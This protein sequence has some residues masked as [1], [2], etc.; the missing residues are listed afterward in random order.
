MK[1]VT[2]EEMQS[3]EREAN[4]SG[5]TYE[6]MMEHAGNGLA[7]EVEQAYKHLKS[8]GVLGLVGPGN[9]GGDTLVALA[10][11]VEKGW[12]A[13]AYILKVRP[14][15]D[16][17]VNRLIS[18]GGSV[19]PIDQDPEFEKL[20]GAVQSHEVIMDGVLGTGITLPLKGK[21]AKSLTFIQ[22]VLDQM[23]KKPKIVAVDCPSGVDCDTGKTAPESLAADLTVT[24]AA[25]KVGLLKFPANDLIGELRLVGIGLDDQDSRSMNWQSI[26]REVVDADWVRRRLP[27]RP[28]E[29]HKGTFGTALIVAGSVN[30]T[31]AGLLAGKGA[32]LAGVGL[33]TMAV[34]APLHTALAGHFPE[35]T[36]L[37]LPHE[38][39]VIDESAAEVVLEN[40]GRATAMLL[41]PGFGVEDKTEKFLANLIA[42]TPQSR[43][44]RIGFV[45]AEIEDEK[46]EKISLPP[47]VIDADGLKLLKRIPDWSGKLPETTILTPHPGEMAVLT[48]LS[49]PEIQSNRIDITEHYAR[50]WGHVVMLKGANTVIAEPN[51]RTAVIP[52][53]SPAL[54]RAGTGDVLAGIIVGLRAQGLEAFEAAV[55]G[56]WIHAQSGLGAA[57]SK[58][59][60]I[61]VLAGDLL[62][63]MIDVVAGLDSS[64]L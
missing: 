1:L 42:S 31:G 41:G 30:Y 29:A 35:G 39:G 16:P 20:E 54:A 43:R 12:S 15:D 4:E 37:I 21:I 45:A 18:I 56:G 58:G 9:N 19:I 48:G 52:V 25:I 34:P 64:P 32:Y 7:Y 28:R 46:E 17:L 22:N 63:A 13:T 23:P 2:V 8:G 60:T 53:A 6:M 10:N 5:L 36:W 47:L 26:K 3:V 33:V 14:K 61:S 49:V 57:K 51:G 44:V 38:M 62:E 27:N 59:T 55:S 50:K 11:L 40:L 24:M